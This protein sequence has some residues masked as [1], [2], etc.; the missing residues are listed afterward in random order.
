VDDSCSSEDEACGSV[1]GSYS[2]EDEACGLVNDSCSSEV[3]FCSSEGEV[4]SAKGASAVQ[5]E[6]L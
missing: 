6:T 4:K 2:S 1:D 3:A 5:G